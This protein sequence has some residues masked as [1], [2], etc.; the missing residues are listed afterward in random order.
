M[1]SCVLT[2][3]IERSTAQRDTPSETHRLQCGDELRSPDVVEVHVDAIWSD[4]RTGRPLGRLGVVVECVVVTGRRQGRGP[5][6]AASGA[7]DHTCGSKELCEPSSSRADGTSGRRYENDV[8]RTHLRDTG[9]TDVGRETGLAE[10]A[11]RCTR[12]CRCRCQRRSPPLH[13]QLHAP[14]SRGD[15]GRPSRLRSPTPQRRSPR[16]SPSRRA[17][18]RS[19]SWWC[20]ASRS[21]QPPADRRIDAHDDVAQEQLSWLQCGQVSLLEGEVL[22]YRTA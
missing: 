5:S 15:D 1:S 14:A 6:P 13:R 8:A 2:R 18:A 20:S 16:R 10:D 3:R 19:R 21:S 17:A 12:R 22:R 4:S 7:S 9:E 11:E